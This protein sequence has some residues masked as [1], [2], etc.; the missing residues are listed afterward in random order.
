MH[1]IH[2][3][4]SS[5]IVKVTIRTEKVVNAIIVHQILMI[6]DFNPVADLHHIII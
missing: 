2:S 3:I 4:G 5:M 1:K 6:H